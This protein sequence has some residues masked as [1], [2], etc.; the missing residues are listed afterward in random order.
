MKDYKV[1]GYFNGSVTLDSVTKCIG[2][3]TDIIFSFWVSPEQGVAGAAASAVGN[4]DIINSVKKAGKKCILAAGGSTYLPEVADLQHAKEYG[5]ALAE[6]AL[7]NGFDGVDLDI[8]NIQMNQQT[9]QWLAAVT[10]AVV[11]VATEKKTTL[12]ISHAPQAP[13]FHKTEGYAKLEELTAGRIDYYNIQYYNQGSY[14][15]QA[16]EDFS[17]M[18][19]IEYLG[20]S[21]E[22][23]VKSIITQDSPKVPFEKVVIGK[24][25]TKDDVGSSNSTGYI[26]TCALVDILNQAKARKI[27]FGGVMGWKIDSDIDGAWGETLNE[28]LN[29]SKA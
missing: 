6:Y 8:E 28:C 2:G 7:A 3:Y 25:I 17:S 1:V 24:P 5:K 4:S 21:N 13:Y 11:S 29:G 22:T 20:V 23:S 9:L 27:P 10:N 16:Y 19:D 26:P 15:Y 18:F 14:A 12:Q